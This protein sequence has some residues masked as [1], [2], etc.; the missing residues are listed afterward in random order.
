MKSRSLW[1]IIPIVLG[2]LIAYFYFERQS[3]PPEPA[4]VKPAAVQTEPEPP[5]VQNAPPAPPE[6]AA[7]PLPTL[8]DSDDTVRQTLGET[9][10]AEATERYLVSQAVIRKFVITVDNLTRES[11]NMRVRVMPAVGGTFEVVRRNDEIVLDAANYARYKPLVSLISGADTV[12]LADI[13]VR[14]YPL[15]QQAYEELGYPSQQFHDRLMEVIA[16]LLAAPE[17][18]DPIRLVRPHVLYKYAD[19]NLEARSAGQKALIRIGAENSAVIK[20]KLSEL[21]KELEARAKPLTEG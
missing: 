16:H 19:P 6:E 2:L 1:L 5:P 15:L 8:D 4:S 18:S 11:V 20:A 17:V 14:Y 13:Y 12:A 21:E 7:E 9:L 3:Q 10:G